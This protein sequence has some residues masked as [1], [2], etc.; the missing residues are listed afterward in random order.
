MKWIENKIMEY[1][2]WLKDNTAIRE[3]KGTGWFAISTPFVG[4]FNDC[5]EIFVKKK[6]DTEILLSDDGETLGNLSLCGVDIYRSAKRKNYLQRILNN[7]GVTMENEEIVT[8]SNGADFAKKKHALISAIMSI[9]DMDLLANENVS[10]MFA[11]DVIAYVKQKD[12]L[13]TPMFIVRGKSGLDFNFDFQVA[14]K[15]S[16]LVVKSFGNL[17]Q[18]NVGSFI[19]CIQDVKEIREE[20]TG[21]EFKSLAIVNDVTSKPSPKLIDAFYKYNTG[22]LFWSEKDENKDVF[23]VA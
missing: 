3:D 17:R 18:N 19:F 6:S 12:I 16:E 4:L 5:V 10:S 9:S 11:E 8:V 23:N 2:S 14:G 7:Y 20:A 13:Y 15:K 21:K 1:Y 22:V